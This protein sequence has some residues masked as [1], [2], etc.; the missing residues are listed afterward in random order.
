MGSGRAPGA[1]GSGADGR[2]VQTCWASALQVSSPGQALPPGPGTGC[3][4][5]LLVIVAANSQPGTGATVRSTTRARATGRRVT[6]TERPDAP[7]QKP[8]KLL[9]QTGHRCRCCSNIL[10]VLR[11]ALRAIR[12][13][14]D[15]QASRAMHDC[16]HSYTVPCPEA[17]PNNIYKRLQL[18][19]LFSDVLG[20]APKKCKCVN[21][22]A[23]IDVRMC[24]IGSGT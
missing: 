23:H 2:W 4:S 15:E 9:P 1:G 12:G 24:P 19:R 22:Q 7:L 3:T 14:D 11:A 5:S 16:R 6:T 8:R 17:P 21:G 10:M 20:R 18:P 13:T